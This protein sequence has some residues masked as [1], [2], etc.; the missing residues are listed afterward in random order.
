MLSTEALQRTVL[1]TFRRGRIVFFWNAILGLLLI[2]VRAEDDVISANAT[3]VKWDFAEWCDV[4]R[5]RFI[6]EK[7]TLGE[8]MHA[9]GSGTLARNGEESDT[10]FGYFVRY[11]WRD[12]VIIFSSN[13]E[14][15]GDEHELEEI[16]IKPA[17][18][19]S[20]A[21]TLPFI[22]GSITF[23]F[24]MPGMSFVDLRRKLGPIWTRKGYAYYQYQ[25][26]KK[27]K[28]P[29]G[30]YVD[31]DVSAWLQVKKTG[32]NVEDILLGHLTSS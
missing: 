11:R 28:S 31:F 3:F 12:Q 27:I 25:G 32:E 13:N 8:I 20:D 4:G 16:E 14:M 22:H 23:P 30:R 1:S 17:H 26:H 18:E 6:F 2:P 21:S 29:N 24:G 9:F 10:V 19:I 5:Q 15:G 7:T